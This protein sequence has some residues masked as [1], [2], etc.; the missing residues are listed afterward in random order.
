[1]WCPR[2]AAS[3]TQGC[4]LLRWAKLGNFYISI[5]LRK[6]KHQHDLT[7]PGLTNP[8]GAPSW[9]EALWPKREV[10]PNYVA[11]A[12]ASPRRHLLWVSGSLSRGS[13]EQRRLPEAGRRCRGAT[14]CPVPP[15]AALRRRFWKGPGCTS[16]SCQR[17][18]LRPPRPRWLPP[19]SSPTNR[20][21]APSTCFSSHWFYHI[22]RHP[23]PPLLCLI[24][25]PMHF[26]L[27]PK[28]PP[29]PSP[30]PQCWKGLAGALSSPETQR[31]C[32]CHSLNQNKIIVCLKKKDFL[33][34]QG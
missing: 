14:A 30:C 34:N 27:P 16:S 13:A 6:L 26:F 2:P 9:R 11:S 5:K 33:E 32:F 10:R 25:N 18:R 28:C 31:G 19:V 4:T 24:L 17:S 1:M 12:A 20:A 3:C 23:S 15:E 8:V 29:F 21:H 7:F 22:D